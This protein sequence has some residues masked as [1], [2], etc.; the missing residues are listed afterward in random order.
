MNKRAL[1][2]VSDKEGIVEFAKELVKNSYEII[3]TGGTK[4]ILDES[5]IKTIAIDEVTNFPEM[6]DGRVKTLHP[7]VHAGLLSLRDNKEHVKQIQEHNINYIDLVVVNLYP[8]KQTILKE[9]TTLEEAIENIDIGGPSMLRSAAKN[10]RSVTVVTD[11][12]DYA[13]VIDEI[14]S[15]G[16]TT[17]ETR[18]RLAA[19]VFR[20][21]AY[22]DSLI[23][24]YL[25]EKVGEQFPETMTIGYE[26]KQSLR[27]GENPHQQASF[28]QDINDELSIASAKQLQGKELSYN[29][30]QDANAAIQIMSEFD[31]SVVVGLK[32]M[33]PCGLGTGKTVLEAWNNCYEG[34]STS[35]FGGIVST[36]EE[37]DLPTAEKMSKIFLEIIIAP[38]YSKEALDVF[39]KKKNLRVMQLP[40]K[41]RRRSKMQYVSVNGGLL[42]QEYDLSNVD[43]CKL[44]VVTKTKLTDAQKQDL[45]IGQKVVKHVKSNAIV[46][47]KDK[48]VIGVGAG[49]MNRVGA[50]KI[51]LDWCKDK[52]QGAILA[53]DAFFPFNDVVTLAQQ[54]GI[55]AIIQPGGSIRDNESIEA[56]DGANIAMAFTGMRHFKH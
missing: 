5:G 26:K 2:S 19:K 17:L 36:N 55:S 14:N 33:N 9:G 37:I 27:Y 54:Y 21:T 25:S 40:L 50:A 46:I 39:A 49:Q 32:H 6:L 16:D 29:N 1:I 51:A 38:S 43:D 34:D 10:Y 47:V 28:Y 12:E 15:K 3:S 44:D 52:S 35:I 8:F 4:K 41:G 7:F 20:T 13:N 24:N 23:A 48:Q 45:I 42:C 53:S 31:E 56:A 11:K 22:Y 30:I 18:E